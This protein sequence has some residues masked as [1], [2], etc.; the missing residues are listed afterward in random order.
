MKHIIQQGF[1]NW[2]QKRIPANRVQ[3][4]SH[5]KIF[6]LPSRFGV[7]FLVLCALLFVLGTNYQNNVMKLLCTFLLSLFLLH[8]FSSYI[9]FSRL[10][11]S[12][13]GAPHCFEGAL[14]NAHINIGFQRKRAQGIVHVSWWK[15][16]S[17]KVISVHLLNEENEVL[18]PF[19]A[20]Q[21]GIHSLSRLTLRCDYPLGLFKCWTH[22]DLAQQVTVFPQ[23]QTCNVCLMDYN[24]SAYSLDASVT[25]AGNEDLSGLRDFTHSDPLSKVAWKQAAK[26]NQWVVKTFEET[27][28]QSGYL[29]LASSS[30]KQ[31]EH[32]LSE[33]CYQILELSKKD[34][35]FGLSLPSIDIDPDKGDK[36]KFKCLHA[37][38][39]YPNT[40]S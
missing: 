14:G 40:P 27:S 36:H 13:L 29:S 18:I 2:L 9:N 7:W 1:S 37:L 4:L 19:Y 26:N 25:Q 21:R 38:A 22:L 8:L 28:S 23:P 6:I 34:V 31:R 16:P 5:Q 17:P 11:I 12:A 20:M 33:L 39:A 35:S 32:Q 15:I 10:K 3:R 30:A 24:N